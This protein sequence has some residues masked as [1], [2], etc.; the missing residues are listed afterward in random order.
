LTPNPPAASSPW[1]FFHRYRKELMRLRN[2]LNEGVLSDDERA[3]YEALISA[4][5]FA[6]I[7]K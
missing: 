5:D 2:G 4:E 1:V 3:E 7:L 6:A